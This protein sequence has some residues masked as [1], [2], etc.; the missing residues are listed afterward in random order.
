MNVRNIFRRNDTG[1]VQVPEIE[2]RGD[3]LRVES[4]VEGEDEHRVQGHGN[5]P[6]PEAAEENARVSNQKETRSLRLPKTKWFA[7]DWVTPPPSPCF[8]LEK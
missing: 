7:E 2:V 5:E 8:P 4:G 6:N 1:E 3:E